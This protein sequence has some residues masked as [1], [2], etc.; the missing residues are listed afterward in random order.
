MTSTAVSEFNVEQGL[1]ALP[2]TPAR[3]VWAFTCP[4]PKCAC[5]TAVVL[6][7]PGER[8]LL[9]ERGRRVADAWLRDAHYGQTAQDLKGVTAF[10]VHLD[11][12]ELLPTVGDAPLDAAAHPEVREV[13]DRLDDDVLDAIAR[14]WVTGK[15]ERLPPE[16]GA[17]GAKI[18]IEGWRQGDRVAW[19]NAR[20]SLRG[21]TYV[22][23]KR[24]FEAVEL[25]CVEPDCDCGEVKV[26]FS[27]V[28]PRGAPHPGHVVFDGELATVHPERE[29]QRE[30]LVELWNAYC[31]RYPRYPD[32][33]A[34][35]SATMHG[36]AG[37]I[38]AAPPRR[39]VAR[40]E[41]CPCGSGKQFR[42]V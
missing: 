39:K 31:A 22:I 3:W 32:R 9:L 41:P 16:P 29:Q 6:S 38:V 18:E 20:P 1:I 17:D 8:E 30:R 35:R 15:G 7:L 33:F 12:H 11:T 5:R 4:Y 24:I 37:H 26:D 27:V 14:V 42:N 34:Q 23:G 21:D 40:N 36:L 2:G 28:I 25:Y 10:A 19:D 13:A